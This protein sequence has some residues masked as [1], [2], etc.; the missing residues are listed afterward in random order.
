[1]AIGNQTVKMTTL[2]TPVTKNQIRLV[3]EKIQFGAIE[4]LHLLIRSGIIVP[5]SRD[6]LYRAVIVILTEENSVSKNLIQ[7]AS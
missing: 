7:I 3:I 6:T 2:P 5:N 1:M 4:T